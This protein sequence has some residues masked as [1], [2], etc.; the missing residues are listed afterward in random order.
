[1]SHFYYFKVNSHALFIPP[2]KNFEISKEQLRP[3]GL[4]I[5]EI[6]KTLRRNKARLKDT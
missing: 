6:K 2:F 1:M 3:F 5:K 4:K